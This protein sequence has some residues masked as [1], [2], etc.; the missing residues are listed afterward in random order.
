MEIIVINPAIAGKS[1]VKNGGRQGE[2]RLA[3]ALGRSYC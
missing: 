2:V 1:V 3:K